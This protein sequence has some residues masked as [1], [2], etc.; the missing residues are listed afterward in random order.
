M[1]VSKYLTGFIQVVILILGALLAAL[2]DGLTLVEALQLVALG[3]GA[4]VTYWAP[5][6]DKGWAAALKVLGAVIGA[7]IAA[8]IPLL[9]G[10]WNAS[11]TII[12]VLAAINAL[13]TQLGVDVR[14]DAAKETLGKHVYVD[15]ISV[16]DRPA[17]VVALTQE[18][19]LNGSE[20]ADTSRLS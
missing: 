7:V 4:I 12:V 11:S 3:V 20:A 10:E 5:L 18:P 8:L 17:A 13:A 9:A 15:S 2:E 19:S 14:V 1:I 16:V 6:L